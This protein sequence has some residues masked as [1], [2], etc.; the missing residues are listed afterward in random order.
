MNYKSIRSILYESE[1]ILD[2]PDRW[3]E[4]LPILAMYQDE[5]SDVFIYFIENEMIE[6]KR[7]II[8]SASSGNI[9]VLTTDEIQT[10]L[11]LIAK[12]FPSKKIADYDKYFAQKDE[13]E[14]IYEQAH[15][16]II[17]NPN[18]SS[19]L[20]QSVDDLYKMVMGEEFY[21]GI[22]KNIAIK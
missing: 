1:E 4:A 11:G 5:L 10:S 6:I 22:Y 15:D 20:P 18:Q 16:E 3:Q 13:Y 8:I 7:A 17:S 9:S 21:N 2:I 12:E 19:T 14:R